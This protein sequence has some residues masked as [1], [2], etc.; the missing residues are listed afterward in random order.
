MTLFSLLPYEQ[1]V[2]EDV[3]SGSPA[4]RE[5]L[6]Q[7]TSAL[8]MELARAVNTGV[9]VSGS[10][11]NAHTMSV[12]VN[13]H[14]LEQI[15]IDPN[16]IEDK[17]FLSYFPELEAASEVRKDVQR[18][19][20]SSKKAN[21]TQYSDYIERVDTGE[22]DGMAPAIILWSPAPLEVIQLGFMNLAIGV[23]PRSTKLI[24]VD[25][26]TQLAARFQAWSRRP[27][28]KDVV[29]PVLI[30]HGRPQDWARQTFHDVNVFGVKP[31]AALAIGMDN[32]DPATKVARDLPVDVPF[33]RGRINM[34]DRQLS[35]QARAE[36][37]FTTIAALRG[38]VVT[39]AKGIS[40]IALGTKPLKL[41]DS[42]QARLQRQAAAWWT[43]L[44]D[45][46]GPA[47][48]SEESVASSPAAIAALG[49]VGHRV[50]Q[51]GLDPEAEA[52]RLA[53]EVNWSKG[54]HWEGIA[55]K[56]TPK[57]AF[58]LGGA[59]ETAYAIFGALTD[60][61]NAGYQRIRG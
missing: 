58:S 22:R 23:V 38:S 29:V 26:E 48:T 33:L 5:P 7:P 32:Y 1:T 41:D 31:N 25:G 8:A 18:L 24:G 9:L 34:S 36:G 61:E 52:A 50:F 4:E 15:T 56:Y 49:A 37:Q 12:G 42:E 43:A 46:M 59:K 10:W 14:D 13:G 55:G 39:L 20:R 2:Q 28:L 17:K 21:A 16:R 35:K 6:I 30:V 45:Q 60:M 3:M 51:Q 40:G 57:G 53:N 47:L 54:K 19:F 27:E 44:A 11:I